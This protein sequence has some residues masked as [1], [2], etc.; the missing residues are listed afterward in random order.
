MIKEKQRGTEVYMYMNNLMVD[1]GLEESIKILCSSFLEY[2]L[3][4]VIFAFLSAQ[5]MEY[6]KIIYFQVLFKE[7]ATKNPQ[8]D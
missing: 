8:H 1:C 5:K 7:Q 4:I 2:V 6:V 3:R